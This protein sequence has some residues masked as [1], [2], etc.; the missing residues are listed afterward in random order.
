M[1]KPIVVFDNFMKEPRNVFKIKK[2]SETMN[3][4][5]ASDTRMI[6]KLFKR[7]RKQHLEKCVNGETDE[8]Q[9]T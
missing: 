4:I 1:T 2:I 6:V 3:T 9:V 8:E 5:K 7:Q